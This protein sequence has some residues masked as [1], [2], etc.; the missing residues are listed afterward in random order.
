MACEVAE[1]L[2]AERREQLCA[3]AGVAHVGVEG[4]GLHSPSTAGHQMVAQCG[5]GH[6]AQVLL[7]ELSQE[8]Q[9]IILLG[10]GQRGKEVAYRGVVA[11][12]GH[13]QRGQGVGVVAVVHSPL[14]R[15]CLGGESGG[16]G[17][18]HRV[19]QGE[20]LVVER[21]LLGSH[22]RNVGP[23]LGRHDVDV[24]SLARDVACVEREG[25]GD[26]AVLAERGLGESEA[27][28]L[29]CPYEHVAQS[30]GEEAAAV[31]VG[32]FRAHGVELGVVV[33]L[34]FHRGPGHGLAHVVHHEHI[35]ARRGGVVVDDVDFRVAG[36]AAHHLL[37]AVV[38]A[39]HLG[40]HQHSARGGSVEPA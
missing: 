21:A 27:T 14:A 10:L 29:G 28:V 37:R 6:V 1:Q 40:V 30:G 31:A 8:S 20:A 13:E 32:E 25:H 17:V 35:Q 15:R 5:L 24:H 3:Y 26:E 38:F 16:V 39:K 4:L 22:W 9:R 33:E 23:L 12:R 34:V 11:A 7:H 2:G 36:R 19:L 18:A